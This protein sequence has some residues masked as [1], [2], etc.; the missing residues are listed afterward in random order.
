MH[1]ACVA[2]KRPCAPTCARAH[3]HTNTLCAR[4]FPPLRSPPRVSPPLPCP[5][6]LSVLPLADDGAEDQGEPGTQEGRL[7]A[8]A[9]PAPLADMGQ[10]EVR[11]PQRSATPSSSLFRSVS[12]ASASP[13]PLQSR[14]RWNGGGGGWGEGNG[15]SNQGKRS[16]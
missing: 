4:S 2:E 10:T 1:S 6:L 16:S 5:P 7:N 14:R 12:S 8:H 3:T 11:C 9:P 13:S 15:G